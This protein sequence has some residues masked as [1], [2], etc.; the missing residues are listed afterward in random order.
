MA[1]I[2]RTDI[3]RI[4][5]AWTCLVPVIWLAAPWGA[6]LS[7]LIG[8]P[9]LWCAVIPGFTAALLYPRSLTVIPG[10]AAKG[11]RQMLR[12]SVTGGGAGSGQRHGQPMGQR[13]GLRIGQ[14]TAG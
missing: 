6:S 2:I 13:T 9:W 4:L 11:L 7:K 12:R 10:L 14:R 1:S 3:I 8:P 5:L